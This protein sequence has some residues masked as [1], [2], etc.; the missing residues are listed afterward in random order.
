MLGTYKSANKDKRF[1]HTSL[2]HFETATNLSEESR[3]ND[4]SLEVDNKRVEVK[5]QNQLI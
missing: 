3:D 2:A 4:Q 5:V 1:I